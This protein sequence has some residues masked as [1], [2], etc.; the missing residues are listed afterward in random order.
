MMRELIKARKAA[1]IQAERERVHAQREQIIRL[2]VKALKANVVP[3]EHI[4][5][6]LIEYPE[7]ADRLGYPVEASGILRN[8]VMG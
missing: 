7:I 1:D 8:P 4:V 5:P 2:G 6:L 3:E